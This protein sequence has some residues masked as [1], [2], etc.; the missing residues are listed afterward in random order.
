MKRA[1]RYSFCLIF[2]LL[3]LVKNSAAHPAWGIVIDEEGTIYFASISIDG[4]VVWKLSKEGKLELLLDHFHAHNVSL[5]HEG[6]LLTAQGEGQHMMIRVNRDHSIDTLALS[7]DYREFN[8]GN[9][10]WSKA[11][12]Q[13]VFGAKGRFHYMKNGRK[14]P[15]GDYHFGWN[16]TI[17]TDE[18]G[19]LYG[20]DLNQDNGVLVRIDKNGKSKIMAS[21]L[22][23]KLDRPKDRHGDVLLGI[24]K[25]PRGALYI[26]ELAGQ[27]II[28]IKEDGSKSTFYKSGGDW[29]PTGITF[30]KGEAYILEFIQ[31]SE[32]LKGPRITKID[33]LGTKTEV[34]HY[35]RFTR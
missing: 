10:T 11:R 19:N 23:S 5:D 14:E 32:G 12:N 6:N 13:I 20:P 25:G 2:L 21:D 35:R 4:E 28:Q 33:E 8:G 16:Q 1:I 29:F 17:Y 9:A 26:A 34:F 24:G 7:R 27:R 18:E 3:F 31:D 30:H 15:F 22:I